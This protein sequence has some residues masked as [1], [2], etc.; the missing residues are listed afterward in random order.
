MPSAEHESSVPLTDEQ[1]TDPRDKAIIRLLFGMD[2]GVVAS[3]NFKFHSEMLR[4]PCNGE[5]AQCRNR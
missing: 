1:L 5:G 3:P 4:T 2:P